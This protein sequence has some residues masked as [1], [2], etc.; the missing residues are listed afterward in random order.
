MIKN[1]NLGMEGGVFIPYGF[2]FVASTLIFLIGFRD[3]EN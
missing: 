3:M 2:H 1:Y